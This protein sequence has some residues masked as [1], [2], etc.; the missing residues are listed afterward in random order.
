MRPLADAMRPAA[1]VNLALDSVATFARRW[2]KH[3]ISSD[4]RCYVGELVKGVFR[5]RWEIPSCIA[6]CYSI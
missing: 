1:S 4:P 6:C 3:R 2:K 5:D